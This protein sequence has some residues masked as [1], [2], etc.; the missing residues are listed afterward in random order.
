MST[1]EVIMFV[2]GHLVA[3]SL[4]LAG[5]WWLSDNLWVVGL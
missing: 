2:L 3:P 4:L 1:G 5:M